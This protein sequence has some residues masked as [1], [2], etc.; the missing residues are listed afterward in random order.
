MSLSALPTALLIP[1]INLIPLGLAGA[2]LAGLAHRPGWRRLGRGL[3]WLALIGLLVLSLPV[4]A[5]AL[6]ASLEVGL[7]RGPLPPDGAGAIVILSAEAAH[8]GGDGVFPDSGIG[9]MTL[10]R[11]RAGAALHRRTGLPVLVTGGVLE[12]GVTPI[13]TQMAATLAAEFATPVRW[14]EDRSD[15]TWQNAEFSAAMLKH[16]GIDSAY[17]VTHAWHMRRSLMAFDHF[18]IAAR[19]AP[20][21]FDRWP[22]PQFDDFVPSVSALRLS[23][24]AL[25][26]WIGCLD[27]ALKS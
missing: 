8:P 1:P 20:V 26:E 21:R 15:D 12:Q 6:I 25:H 3:M 5:G 23:Y 7:A 11:M 19:P 24:F 2:A 22:Q 13:G 10:D 27:Y 16:D 17:I 14:V 18:G 4:T 9:E